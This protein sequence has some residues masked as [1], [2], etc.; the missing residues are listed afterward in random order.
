MGTIQQRR[1][2]KGG[3]TK[4]ERKKNTKDEIILLQLT[5][6]N[7]LLHRVAR[8]V[9]VDVHALVAEDGLHLE[10]VVIGRRHDG[11]DEDLARTEPEGPL[12]GKVFG[13]D[14]DEALETAVDGTVD[15]DRSGTAGAELFRVCSRLLLLLLLLFG[16]GI[17]VCFV[18]GFGCFC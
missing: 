4:K 15:H 5:R 7:L 18:G 13:Q 10:H 1:M 3:R 16:F 2:E 9:A 12:S 6:P 14:G 11:D 8:D 17:G